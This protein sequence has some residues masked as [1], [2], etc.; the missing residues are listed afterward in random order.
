MF[1]KAVT[2]LLLA[3]CWFAPAAFAQGAYPNRV[4]R[5]IVPYAAGGPT[6]VLARVMAQKLGEAVGQNVIVDNKPGASGIPGTDAIA[7][8]PPR[9]KVFGALIRLSWHTSIINALR[10]CSIVAACRH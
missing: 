2:V 8:A 4:I 9:V 6:D 1:K 3:T 10:C 5:M 7:K